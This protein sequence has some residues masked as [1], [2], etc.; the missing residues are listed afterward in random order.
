MENEQLS[1]A[2]PA[3]CC[4]TTSP[5]MHRG[6]TTGSSG[7]SQ[8]RV[9]GKHESVNQSLSGTRLSCGRPWASKHRQRPRMTEAACAATFER[10]PTMER[11]M[12]QLNVQLSRLTRS[13]RRAR[14]VELPEGKARPVCAAAGQTVPAR[15]DKNTS[16]LALLGFGSGSV[17]SPRPRWCPV[18]TWLIE[19]PFGGAAE[20]FQSPPW[21]PQWALIF[22]PALW[23]LS[24]DNET[25]V[26]TLMPMVM[27]DQHRLA[28]RT[29]LP[30][31]GQL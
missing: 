16:N 24:P 23:S 31:R 21:C 13:L 15:P 18:V 17:L 30:C 26:Y 8:R 14:T 28:S 6:T 19:G 22:N 3:S 2:A 5:R 29:G 20:A 25:A 7:A 11:A 4:L 12:E 1:R 10:G 27:A 9:G